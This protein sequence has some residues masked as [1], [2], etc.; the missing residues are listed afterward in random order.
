MIVKG[1]RV[2]VVRGKK[3][4]IGTTGVV[5]WSGVGKYGPRVGLKDASG[6]V[7]W[8]DAKNVD[9][10]G[11]SAPAPAPAA[12]TAPLPFDAVEAAVLDARLAAIEATLA[13]ILAALP[14]PL[15]AAA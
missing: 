7:H 2:T 13:K 12:A 9:V 4:P 8:T 10:V 14:A 5:I 15:A 11:S 1:S 3:V 6:E